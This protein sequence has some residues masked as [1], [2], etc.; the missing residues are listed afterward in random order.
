M[1]LALAEAAKLP[2]PT[3][4]VLG[5]AFASTLLAVFMLVQAFSDRSRYTSFIAFGTIWV[6]LGSLDF[7]MAVGWFS[8]LQT[9]ENLRAIWCGTYICALIYLIHKKKNLAGLMLVIVWILSSITFSINPL[10][11][12]TTSFV[13][14]FG[15]AF[16]LHARQYFKN[17]YFSSTVLGA[18]Y[19]SMTLQC[20]LFPVVMNL[21]NKRALFFGYAC[22]LVLQVLSVFF[23]WIHL[24]RELRGQAPVR[25]KKHHGILFFIVIFVSQIV[26]QI[27]LIKN[28]FGN[29]ALCF[30][31]NLITVA[32]T[33]A[34][35]FYERN[36]LGPV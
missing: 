2:F 4:A 33:T 21:E 10:L 11:T 3:E 1:W 8:K 34:L 30:T 14:S 26:I 35:Y 29:F 24:P 23:G 15:S 25:I 31:F 16:V 19:A 22:Y 6:I 18:Y 36:Q 17:K 20:A 13:I 27:D 5:S 9:Y 7:A 32:A 28:P 12:T